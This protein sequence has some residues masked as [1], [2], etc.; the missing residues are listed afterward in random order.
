MS[1][2]FLTPIL[3]KFEDAKAKKA[4]RIVLAEHAGTELA[5]QHIIIVCNKQ[6]T[7]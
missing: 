2:Y 1:A 4:F 5:G 6:R 3:S 7:G